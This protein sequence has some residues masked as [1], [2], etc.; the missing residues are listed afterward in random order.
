MAHPPCACAHES[1]RLSESCRPGR[2]DWAEQPLLI[3]GDLHDTSEAA[4]N[5]LLFAPP[6]F[7]IGTGGYAHPDQGDQQRLWNTGYAMQL[8]NDYPRTNQGRLELIDHILASHA[9]IGTLADTSAVPLDI[10]SIG[11]H[12]QTTPRTGPPSDHRPV[13]AMFNL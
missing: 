5:Q 10:P 11:A 9:L 3:C 2:G 1:T 6:G 12:P 13:L 7:Q 4:T 8:P